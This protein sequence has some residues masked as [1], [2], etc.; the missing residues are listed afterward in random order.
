MKITE[1]WITSQ[2]SLLLIAG[3]STENRFFLVI[4]QKDYSITHQWSHRL[5]SQSLEPLLIEGLIFVSAL[6]PVVLATVDKQKLRSYRVTEVKGSQHVKHTKTCPLASTLLINQR[7]W[8][9]PCRV[10]SF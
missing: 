1:R 5:H 7:I 6:M 3:S 4:P 10:A 2:K 8:G 9:E